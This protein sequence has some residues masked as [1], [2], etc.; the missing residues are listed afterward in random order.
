VFRDGEF[1]EHLERVVAP[2]TICPQTP[3]SSRMPTFERGPRLDREFRRLSPELQQAFVAALRL[4]IDALRFATSDVP[5]ATSGQARAG[6]D[7][8]V[9]MTFAAD[10]RAT[11]EYGSERTPGDPHVIWRRIGGHE[12]LREP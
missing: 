11:F 5:A 1:I 7:R 9:E 2:R 8:R 3:A 6:R 10:G 12:I 4:F